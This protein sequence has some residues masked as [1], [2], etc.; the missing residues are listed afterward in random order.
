MR[1]K[2]AELAKTLG[3]TQNALRKAMSE[4]RIT[5]FTKGA[6]G[7]EF[8][9]ELAVAEYEMNTIRNLSS[10]SRFQ[11]DEDGG[12]FRFSGGEDDED[13]FDPETGKKK[14]SVLDIEPKFWTANQALQAK[15]IYSA[16]KT[17]HELEVQEGKFYRKAEADSEF[18]RIASTFA[19]GLIAFPTKIKQKIP[20]ITDE[21]IKILKQLC[22]DLASECESKL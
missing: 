21:H 20:D 3:I 13:D 5:A 17:K 14:K 6:K 9:R 12:D 19:R 11:D 4:G 7:Y 10:N 18:N 16:L 2:L 15:T 22:D 8:D 1:I